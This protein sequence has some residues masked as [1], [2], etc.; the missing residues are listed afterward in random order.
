MRDS[1]RK[2]VISRL[3]VRSGP[4]FVP[5]PFEPVAK[6]LAVELLTFEDENTVFQIQRVSKSGAG[7]PRPNCRISSSPQESCF[8]KSDSECARRY[9]LSSLVKSLLV[10]TKTGR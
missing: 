1:L 9:W 6:E 2:D 8:R 3:Q 10:S 4:D 5:F 7:T